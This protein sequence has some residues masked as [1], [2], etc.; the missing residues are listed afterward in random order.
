MFSH[1]QA[2]P[3]FSWQWL[4]WEVAKETLQGKEVVMLTPR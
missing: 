4:N 3:S 1:I 2:A